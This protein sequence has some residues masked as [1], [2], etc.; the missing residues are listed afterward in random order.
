MTKPTYTKKANAKRAATASL[1]KGVV[2]GVDY[3]VD[4]LDDGR[5]TYQPVS[6]PTKPVDAVSGT[7][8]QPKPKSVTAG[9]DRGVSRHDKFGLR[10]GSAVSKAAAMFERGG[11]MADVKKAT[12]SNQYNILQKLKTVGHKVNRKDGLITVAPKAI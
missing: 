8:G 9:R 4:K 11:T 5:F 7:E 10:T 2:E 3:V 12:G 1:G 6:A